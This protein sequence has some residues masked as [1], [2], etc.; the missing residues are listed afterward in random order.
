[1]QNKVKTQEKF[2]SLLNFTENEIKILENVRFAILSRIEWDK[3]YVKQSVKNV[4]LPKANNL[5]DGFVLEKVL[6]LEVK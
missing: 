6:F 5:L 3:N 1:M 2:E 4:L